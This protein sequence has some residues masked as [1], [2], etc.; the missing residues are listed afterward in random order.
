MIPFAL[1]IT[2]AFAISG[3]ACWL[4][5]RDA[6][7]DAKRWGLLYGPKT[8]PAECATDDG[9]WSL[10]ARDELAQYRDENC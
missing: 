7:K 3:G 10:Y 6:K 4:I 1:F 5:R 8:W 2:A 9:F